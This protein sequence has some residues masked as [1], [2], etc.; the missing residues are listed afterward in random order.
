MLEN[1]YYKRSF[2]KTKYT[3]VFYTKPNTFICNV[4]NMQS[5]MNTVFC[6]TQRELRDIKDFL[7]TYKLLFRKYVKSTAILEYIAARREI[8]I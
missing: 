5:Y 2:I 1:I 3:T 4:S 7:Y 6:S 8:L